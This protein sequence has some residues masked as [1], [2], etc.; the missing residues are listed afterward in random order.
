MAK[1][2]QRTQ[3]RI[4]KVVFFGPEST[5]KTTLAKQ[6][7]TLYNTEWV[8]E[9]ARSYL[10]KKY[11]ETK[12]QCEIKDLLPI[13]KG[14]LAS[15]NKLLKKAQTFLFCDTNS[16]E[17]L[18]YANIYFPN[19]EFQEL[20]ELALAQYYDY[21]FLTNIDVPW[22][23]DDLRDRPDDR[24][25]IFKTFRDFLIKYDKKFVILNGELDERIK[26]VKSIIEKQQQCT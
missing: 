13:A 2:H 14:Q 12:L 18:V 7:A 11:D 16:L 22:Q 3:Q 25:E 9:Y 15:E 6:L 23:K 20:E 1:A 19:Q 26:T 4:T 17:T 10:Q 21:Y 8:P 5:G 24:Q